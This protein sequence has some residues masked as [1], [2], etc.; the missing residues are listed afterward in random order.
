MET[1][2]K[3]LNGIKDTGIIA[4]EL[5]D[6]FVSRVVSDECPEGYF[7]EHRL[8]VP[9][10]TLPNTKYAYRYVQDEDF[11]DKYYYVVGSLYTVK[12][13]SKLKIYVTLSNLGKWNEFEDFLK[14]QNLENG[15]NLYTAYQMAQNLSQNHPLFDQFVE[16]VRKALKLSDVQMEQILKSCESDESLVICGGEENE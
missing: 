3:I 8:T 9:P 6:Q 11:I 14:S 13:F 15:I 2:I 16:N 12:T 5:R 7:P 4:A 10:I 1:Y